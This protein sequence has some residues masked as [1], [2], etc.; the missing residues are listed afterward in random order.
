MSTVHE[1]LAAVQCGM[2]VF[3]FSLI[4]NSCV[5]DYEVDEG[6]SVDEVMATAHDR[7]NDLKTIVSRLVAIMGTELETL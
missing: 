6:A 5:T 3:S 2:S 1:V 4:T 7:E